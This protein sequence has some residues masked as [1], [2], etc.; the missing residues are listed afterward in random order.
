[1]PPNDQSTGEDIT[2]VAHSWPEEGHEHK[3]GA[4][5]LGRFDTIDRRAVTPGTPVRLRLINTDVRPMTFE[6]AGTPFKVAAI[7]GTDLNKP[8]DLTGTELELAAGGRYDVI[9]TMPKTP[10]MLTSGE[11]GPGLF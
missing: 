1:L 4:T 3:T 11:D 5:S 9:F 6:L 8:T 2:V 7:D 10:V